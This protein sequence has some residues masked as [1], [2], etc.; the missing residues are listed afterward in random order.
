MYFQRLPV[1][2]VALHWLV[3]V[4]SADDD[5]VGAH[6]AYH[7]FEHL[8]SRGT[9]KYPGGYVDTEA[10]LVRYGGEASA[11]TGYTYTAYQAHVPKRVWR[12]ALDILTDM[13]AA[14]LLREKDI[15]AEREIIRQEIDEWFSSPCGESMCRLPGIL[16]PGHPLGHDQLGSSQDLDAIG[17]NMLGQA[18]RLGY[19]RSRCVLFASGNLEEQELLEEL[20]PIASRLPDHGLSARHKPECYGPLPQWQN[21]TDV[22]IPTEHDDSV[23]YL[24][25]PAPSMRESPNGFLKLELLEHLI[26]AGDLG[27]PLHRIVRERSQLAYSTEFVSSLSPD[28]GYWGLVVQTSAKRTSAV[29]ASFWEVLQGPEI[30]SPD[31]RAYVRDT[32]VGEIEMHDPCPDFYAEEGAER[33]VTYGRV[34]SDAEYLR[35]MLELLENDATDIIDS[36]RPESARTIT[37][38][39][40]D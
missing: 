23:V 28:G 21:A 31:W 36:I 6:G 25:F 34:L 7:W 2:T 29:V 27:S 16:W 33:L 1:N 8:P 39:G 24:L 32:I 35:C 19:D 4:G 20:K 17:T 18:H 5:H 38:L 40:T 3:F 14:P 9:V 12:S 26:T 13:I 11:E 37:F 22:V 10:R 15:V 30:R